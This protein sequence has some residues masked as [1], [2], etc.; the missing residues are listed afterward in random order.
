MR[1][2]H[3]I[4]PLAL[5]SALSVIAVTGC[6]V[7]GSPT[8]AARVGDTE[9]PISE[10]EAVSDAIATAREAQ[11][12]PAPET[13][14]GP[15]RLD[16]AANR[17][18]L[19]QILQWELARAALEGLGE[20]VP[21]EARQQAEQSLE[22]IDLGAA[23]DRAVE[24]IAASLALAGAIANHL[25]DP[26]V[27]EFVDDFYEAQEEAQPGYWDGWLCI[28]GL[29]ASPEAKPEVQARVDDGESLPEVLESAPEGVGPLFQSGASA[30]LPP[31]ELPEDL[32]AS[33]EAVEPGELVVH[34]AA[35][36]TGETVTY[37][38]RVT[39]T[40]DVERD[41]EEV[42]LLIGSA[43]QSQENQQLFT[44]YLSRIAEEAGVEILPTIGSEFDIDQF[45]VVPPPFPLP[46]PIDR[47]Q[48]DLDGGTED[49]LLLEP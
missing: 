16:G 31:S 13:G 26:L 5:L 49:E 35:S 40:R 3:V 42:Q 4:R 14:A 19:S 46:P 12:Q 24:G 1:R 44:R 20:T 25:D 8:W 33:I 34:D 48:I 27:A 17:D 10:V 23:Q 32:R 11:G 15:G 22:G 45:V 2:R 37:F 41:D 28:E 9:I 30:C 7:W 47:S 38:L 18:A 43:L 39:D 21:D 36:Q 29:S 6:D